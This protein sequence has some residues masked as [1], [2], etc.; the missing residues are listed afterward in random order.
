MLEFDP[1]AI[2]VNSFSKYFSMV[3]WRLGLAAN[4]RPNECSAPSLSDSLFLTAPSLSQHAALA[5]LDSLAGLE[6][7]VAVYAQKPQVVP[8]NLAPVSA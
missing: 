7:H 4:C 1:S 2:V 8:K 5:A 3:G 6:A